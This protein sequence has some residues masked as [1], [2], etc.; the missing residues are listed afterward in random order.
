MILPAISERRSIREYQ[1]REVPQDALLDVIRASQYAPTG[2]NNRAV[3]Y[4]V[5][6]DPATKGKLH[7]LLEPRQRFVAD[8]PALI[9][10]VTESGKTIVAVEDLSVAMAF[11][12]IQA[13]ALGLGTVWKHIMPGQRDAVRALLGIPQGRVVLALMPIGLPASKAKPHHDSEFSAA[14][15]HADRW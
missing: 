9:F 12:M 6:R 8:A 11:M 15:I 4:V 13:S 5:V 10:P 1:P 2:M 3:E 7:D 14:K